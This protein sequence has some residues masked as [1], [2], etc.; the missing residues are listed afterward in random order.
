MGDPHD[1]YSRVQY[2]RLI[3]WPAR[4]EREGRLL[5]EALSS[6]PSRRVLDLGCGPGEH[7]RFLHSQG[8][9]VVG[10]DAS[11]A[12]L[13]QAR[14]EPIPEGLDFVEGDLREIGTVVEGDFGGAI[15]L[16]NT[17]PHLKTADDLRRFAR[18]VRARLLPGAPILLQVL[19]YD[20]I[21]GRNERTLPVSLRP[22]PEGGE[23]V[24]LRVMTPQDDG[25]LLFHPT[26]LR[27]RPGHEPPV[28]LKHAREVRL[29]GWRRT[30]LEAALR[31]AGFSDFEAWGGFGRE[32][33]EE[34]E[35]RD[36]VL[37]GR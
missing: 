19:N 6:G 26:T 20:R 28:E 31:E 11:E 13:E 33:F 4:M 14:E 37:L 1:P 18:G 15:C 7:S 17:L 24:F 21:F 3:A 27:L 22:D 23:I 12:M 5:V 10:V 9:E 32:A 30:E 25:T 35:S 8:F 36:L 29:R 34:L 16:G 2:R